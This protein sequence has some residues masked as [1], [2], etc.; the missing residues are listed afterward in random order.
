MTES[1]R[2]AFAKLVSAAERVKVERENLR[3]KHEPRTNAFLRAQDDMLEAAEEV[4]E[5]LASLAD[6]A[7]EVGI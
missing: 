6:R 5:I 2:E 3:H 4:A 1:E 7:V